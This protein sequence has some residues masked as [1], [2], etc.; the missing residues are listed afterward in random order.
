MKRI[1]VVEDEER[2]SSFLQKGLRSNGYTASVA[3]SGHDAL[4]M[5]RTGE[6][7][8]MILDI[9]LPDLD[10]FEVLQRFRSHDRRTPVIVLTAAQLSSAGRDRVAEWRRNLG[11]AHEAAVGR[12]TNSGAQRQGVFYG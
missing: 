7:D 6:F 2:I 10:G 9:G 3:V 1:L 12:W 11:S 8:L 4:A 5:A